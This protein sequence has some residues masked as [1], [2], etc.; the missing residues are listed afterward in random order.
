[1]RKV[2]LV[3]DAEH[4]RVAKGYQRVHAAENKTVEDLLD[5][6]LALPLSIRHVIPL[7]CLHLS[8]PEFGQNCARTP[9]P[10][11]PGS[12]RTGRPPKPTRCDLALR[13]PAAVSSAEL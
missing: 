8:H 10:S 13:V 4:Q 12:S 11:T 9:D 5:Q 6:H 3:E 1:V 2:E 7:I